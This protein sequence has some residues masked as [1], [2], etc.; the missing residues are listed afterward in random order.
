MAVLVEE[1]QALYTTKKGNKIIANI[2]TGQIVK[3][4]NFTILD[5][6]L[7]LKRNQMTILR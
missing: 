3:C 2:D 4:F 5:L 7:T 6:K 1:K